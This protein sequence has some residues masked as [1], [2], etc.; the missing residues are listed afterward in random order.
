MA[1][2]QS[3]I[4]PER[5]PAEFSYSTD[6]TLLNNL[7]PKA[8]ALLDRVIGAGYGDELQVE[9]TVTGSDIF[10]NPMEDEK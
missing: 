2:E 4:H 9:P 7:P 10:V 6:H 5:G 1:K 3:D 8:K